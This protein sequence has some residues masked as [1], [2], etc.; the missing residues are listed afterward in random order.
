MAEGA[1]CQ[2]PLRLIYECRLNLASSPRPSPPKEGTAYPARRRV[3]GLRIGESAA[4]GSPS[5][6]GEGWG[7]G[8]ET[9][10]KPARLRTAD[11]VNQPER[12]KTKL[13]AR[14]GASSLTVASRL[15][16]H[17]GPPA[18]RGKWHPAS[19]SGPTSFPLAPCAHRFRAEIR[20]GSSTF[21]SPQSGA[22]FSRSPRENGSPPS[23]AS[24]PFCRLTYGFSSNSA[25][26]PPQAG[27]GFSRSGARCPRLIQRSNRRDPGNASSYRDAESP[28]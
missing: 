14:Q 23:K 16:P 26:V 4:Y 17:P 13:H 9:H 22:K 18:G 3:E 24:S 12:R 11:E 10:R 8:E 15:P 2:A 6:R 20:A 19:F 25:A 5:P 1:A 21:D 27:G 7:E 28:G